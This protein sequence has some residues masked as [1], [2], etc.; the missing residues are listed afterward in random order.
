M[1]DF[2]PGALAV[3]QN[4]SGLYGPVH[5]AASGRMS[6]DNIVDAFRDSGPAIVIAHVQVSVT[7]DGE[8]HDMVYIVTPVKVG[9]TWREN[10]WH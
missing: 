7:W 9:W 4:T 8:P 2:D 10:L 5:L 3:V 1:S 6:S